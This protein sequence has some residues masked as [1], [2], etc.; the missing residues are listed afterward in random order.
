MPKS[1]P[2]GSGRLQE[3]AETAGRMSA[4]PNGP[5]VAVFDATGWDTHA[6]EG[7]AEG[8]LAGRLGGLDK[9]LD[10]LRR[11]LDNEWARTAVLVCTE[12]GR[13]V[14]VNCTRGTDHGPGAAGFLI[15]GAG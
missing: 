10:A 9:V 2:D 13:T 4:S 8:Q 1:R 15:L 5:R 11:G 6:G 3:I 7:A 14:Q 12:F